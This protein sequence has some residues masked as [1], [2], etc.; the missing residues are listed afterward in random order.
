MACKTALSLQ[1]IDP[2][3][4]ETHC[5]DCTDVLDSAI[6]DLNVR[7]EPADGERPAAVRVPV[8]KEG[9]VRLAPRARDDDGRGQIGRAHV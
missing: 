9:D 1:Q 2:S 7:L 8:E 5:S 4:S 3:A 6:C